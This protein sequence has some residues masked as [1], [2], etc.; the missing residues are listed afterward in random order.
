MEGLGAWMAEATMPHVTIGGCGGEGSAP[1]RVIA[2]ERVE[3][4]GASGDQDYPPGSKILH[5]KAK[6]VKF[7]GTKIIFDK[8]ANRDEASS[9]RREEKDVAQLEIVGR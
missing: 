8:L 1:R 6:W 5:K 4:A 2:E 9:D 7:D 3:V